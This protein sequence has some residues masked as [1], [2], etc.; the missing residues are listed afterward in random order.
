MK[1]EQIKSVADL[2]MWKKQ[3]DKKLFVF[4]TTL[5]FGII[6]TLFGA[7]MPFFGLNLKI[8]ATVSFIGLSLVIVAIIKAQ[9]EIFKL[10]KSE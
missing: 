2:E 8:W 7:A 6:T 4:A 5:I 3:Q 1:K 10:E 9:L